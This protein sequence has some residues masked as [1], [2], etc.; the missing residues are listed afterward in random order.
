M[1]TRE[2]DILVEALR[3]A[4]RTLVDRRSLT[5]FQDTLTDIV[6]SA[7]ETIPGVD[8]GGISIYDG[9]RITSR[10]PTAISIGELDQWQS[11]LDEGPC[12][13]AAK[14]HPEH[15]SVVATDLAGVDA[16]RWPNFAPRAVAQ[17]YRAMLSTQLSADSGLNA[18]LNLYSRQTGGFDTDTRLTAELFAVQAAMLIYG[19]KQASG[20]AS[21]IESRDVIGRAKGIL[22]ERYTV[23][24]DEAFQMLVRASQSTNL[25]LVDVA[26]WLNRDAADRRARN[27]PNPEASVGL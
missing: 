15:G 1:G 25:K 20:L 4:A 16:P 13:D 9:R 17:G 24:D 21:A 7:V 3:S 6:A 2:N 11:R 8:A 27:G 22:M 19:S 26:E 23:G 18:A 12:I 5:E 10:S 14:N